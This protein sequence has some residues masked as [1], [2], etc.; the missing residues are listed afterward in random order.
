MS[1]KYLYA[2]TRSR[3]TNIPGYVAAFALDAETGAI[4]KQLFLLP[5]TNSGGASNSVGP[6]EFS[7][8]YFTMPDSG[9]YFIE[10]WKMTAD[11]S[12]A[13]VVAHLDTA[14]PPAN[15]VWYN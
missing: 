12:G 4:T 3:T 6:A 10:I 5:T 13:E 15:A 14:T 2:S 8:E 7:E 1:P 9:S 11:A